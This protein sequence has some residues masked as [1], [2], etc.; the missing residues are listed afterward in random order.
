[1]PNF[2]P[3]KSQTSFW[4]NFPFGRVYATMASG[5]TNGLGLACWQPPFFSP[6]IS[7]K[8]G[9]DGGWYPYRRFL[10]GWFRRETIVGMSYLGRR[11]HHPRFSG[12]TEAGLGIPIKID[13]NLLAGGLWNIKIFAR[14]GKLIKATVQFRYPPGIAIENDRA[15]THHRFM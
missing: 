11:R 1:M 3:W 15:P 4:A 10:A 7:A 12:W 14:Q 5:I 6:G 2:L 8:F 9:G 13:A